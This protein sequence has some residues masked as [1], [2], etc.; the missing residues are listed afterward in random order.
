V[1]ILPI[2]Q[3]EIS[4]TDIRECVRDGKSI[5]YLVPDGVSEYIAK[6]RLY[7]A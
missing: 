2:P 1:K 6:H 7:Q 5:R 3:L 4:S